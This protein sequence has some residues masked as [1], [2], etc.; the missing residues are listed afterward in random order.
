[1]YQQQNM[2]S[3][4]GVHWMVKQVSG[5][6]SQHLYSLYG[7]TLCLSQVTHGNDGVDK[8]SGVKVIKIHTRK[9]Y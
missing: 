7:G 8:N 3:R 2:L 6:L 4:L 1:M 9:P 5:D